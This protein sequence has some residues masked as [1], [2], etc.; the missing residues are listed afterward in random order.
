MG[1]KE[2][3]LVESPVRTEWYDTPCYQDELK[4][5]LQK[6]RNQTYKVTYCIISFI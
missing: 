2:E 4:N 6:E 3:T 5:I 1:K